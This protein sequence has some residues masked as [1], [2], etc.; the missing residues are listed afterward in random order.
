[1]TQKVSIIVPCYNQENFI[2]E[3]LQSVLD[4]TYE[5]WECLVIDDG[6]QNNSAAVIKS[7]AEKD[8][9][10]KYFYQENAGVSAARNNGLRHATGKYLLMLDGDDVLNP[11]GVEE[12]VEEFEKDPELLVVFSD[13]TSFGEG[14]EPKS[15]NSAPQFG[16]K[17]ILLTNMLHT[18]SMFQRKDAEGVFYDEPL[19]QPRQ[20]WDYWIRL[21]TKNRDRSSN[22]KKIDYQIYRYRKHPKSAHDLSKKDPA[23]IKRAEILIF[24]NHKDVIY[25][26]YPSYY[27]A[28]SRMLFYEQKLEKIYSSKPYKIYDKIVKLFK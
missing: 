25:E 6:S 24:E 9:R 15:S 26:F 5:K 13:T 14:I 4:Q 21:F 23:R 18:S 17:E 3:T 22:V 10:I 1:M 2:R 8:D 12:A 27:R 20:D 7:F 19:G 16:L 11:R 28:L